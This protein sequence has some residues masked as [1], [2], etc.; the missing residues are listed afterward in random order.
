M[1][2]DLLGLSRLQVLSCT[3]SVVCL[4][5]LFGVTEHIKKLIYIK[6]YNTYTYSVIL[7]IHLTDIQQNKNNYGERTH[8]KTK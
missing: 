4:V 2:I 3:I 5:G 8:D 7:E 1:E 6:N